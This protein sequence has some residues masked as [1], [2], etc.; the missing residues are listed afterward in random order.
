MHWMYLALHAADKSALVGV[1]VVVDNDTVAW[2]PYV[3]QTSEAADIDQMAMSCLEGIKS[4]SC[5][6]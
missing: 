1:A 3:D 5:F 2:D 4:F 6:Y